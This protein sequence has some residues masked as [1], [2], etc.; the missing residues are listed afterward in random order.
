MTT[1]AT[2]HAIVIGGSIA[3]L[4]AAR[5]LTDYFERVTIIERDMLP[6]GPDFRKGVPQ[7]HHP[8]AL[9]K[10]G[11][12]IM[13]AYFP[14][15]VKEVKDAGA[16]T[17]NFGSDAR[18]RQFGEWRVT[19]KTDLDSVACSRPLLE[20][21]I[22]S[23]LAANPKVTFMQ[24]C[25]AVNLVADEGKT[26]ATGVKVTS[27]D[28]KRAEITVMA[29]LVVD[30]SGRHSRAPKWLADLGYTAPE[31]TVVNSFPGYAT[32]IYKRREGFSWKLLYM[33]P[34]APDQ[35][36]GAIII[37]MEGDRWHVTLIGINKDYPPTD[38][39]GFM[40]FARSLPSPEL[41]DAIKDAEP[42]SPIWGYREAENRLYHYHTLPHYLDNF[43]VLGDA[44][45][46][47]NPVYGQGMTV[48]SMAAQELGETL[49][50]QLATGKGLT[51]LAGTFQQRL[52]KQIAFP[53]EI[54]TGED[55]RWSACEG[56][57]APTNPIQILVQKYIAQ[58]LLTTNRDPYVLDVFI[59]LQN[60]IESPAVLF[61]PGVM[62]RVFAS[63]NARR[64]AKKLAGTPSRQLN[65]DVQIG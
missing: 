29:D 50:A 59:R 2:Q 41:Y 24:E 32:R 40:A 38:E 47:F 53:W 15:L 60:M 56:G 58:V 30:A 55:M 34:S 57:K 8:H 51:G 19:Y 35:S 17:V 63:M 26:H 23:R 39:E 13:E 9:L 7:A 62:M 49:R 33:Q 20:G 6:D 28:P 21:A 18:W 10:R 54:A 31:E 61:K 45:Y 4:M 1:N 27:R 37:P 12:R 44:V 11:E 64:K 5:A 25:D 16:I 36:R 65:P 46:A 48:A 43:V 3:G 52:A 14:G 42:L 22:R